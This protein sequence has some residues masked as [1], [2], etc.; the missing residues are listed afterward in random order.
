MVAATTNIE[1]VEGVIHKRGNAKKSKHPSSILKTTDDDDDD[2][3]QMMIAL[4]STTARGPG[5]KT[6]GGHG[7]GKQVSLQMF[8]VRSKNSLYTQILANMHT[9][10]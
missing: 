1:Y 10:T 7:A 9:H 5:E 3:R 6:R 4:R 8:V 2:D